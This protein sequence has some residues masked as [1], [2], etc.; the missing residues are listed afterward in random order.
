MPPP[1]TRTV[2]PGR[3]FTVAPVRHGSC[4]GVR[5]SV[6]PAFREKTSASAK[7]RRALLLC[8]A[9]VAAG[10]G[11]PA[12]PAVAWGPP[13]HRAVAA[14]TE[15][16]LCPPAR[17]AVS[18]L[19][20]EESLAEASTWPDRVREQPGWGHTREWHYA[21]LDDH[22]PIEAAWRG[23]RGRLFL[24]LDAQI[25][26]LANAT[27]PREDRVN[28]LRFVAH[29]LPDL[30]Q[31]LH[32]GRPEDAGGNRVT[33]RLGNREMTLHKL[34]DS[35]LLAGTGLAWQD[36]AGVLEA[37]SAAADPDPEGGIEAWAEESR[38]L[39]PWVYDFDP[40]RRVPVISRAYQ[41]TGR[42]LAMLRLAQA[43]RRLEGVL[44]SVWC[45]DEPNESGR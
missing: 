42:H 13:A 25:R 1:G 32:V 2:N 29:L 22:E 19:L 10:L 40:R 41:V 35:G 7:P 12:L 39:R 26:T 24:A 44:E 37:L 31:P 16:R 23:D 34:W 9:L 15:A 3:R 28:A 17:R 33:V 27:A 21:D 6:F 8:A 43:A 4:R 11:L 14:A 36:M 30:H 5:A 20:G 38:A 18:A 45:P